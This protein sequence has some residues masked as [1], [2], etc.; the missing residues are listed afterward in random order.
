MKNI[1]D[2]LRQKEAEIQQ[3]Q[4]DIEAL[5]TAARLLADEN[6]ADSSGSRT[7]SG[8]VA[9]PRVS[10]SAVAAAVKPADTLSPSIGIRQ[11]P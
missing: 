9:S 11:F 1:Y 7:S 10:A 5:R 6:E 2:V 8:T 4:K 3:L